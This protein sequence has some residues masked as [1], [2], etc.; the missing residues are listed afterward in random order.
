MQKGEIHKRKKK[1]IYI[2]VINLRKREKLIYFKRKIHSGKGEKST[3]IKMR[4]IHWCQREIH[5]HKQQLL[6]WIKSIFFCDEGFHDEKSTYVKER[7]PFIQKWG[8]H[9]RTREES[10]VKEKITLT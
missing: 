10:K 8:I 1:N 4:E 7:N 3:Y 2:N 9:L 5:L 6:V